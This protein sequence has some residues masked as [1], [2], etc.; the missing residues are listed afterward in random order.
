MVFWKEH[1]EASSTA[2]E[3]GGTTNQRDADEWKRSA[4]E[5]FAKRQRTQA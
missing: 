1:D 3:L 4:R 5:S 2:S